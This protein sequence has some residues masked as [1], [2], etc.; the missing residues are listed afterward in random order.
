MFDTIYMFIENVEI[1]NILKTFIKA[2]TSKSK[3][4]DTPNKA[5]NTPNK[6]YDTPNK[7]Y[8]IPK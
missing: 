1:H 3:Y 2:S 7:S 6:S 5:Y 4:Y 8:N